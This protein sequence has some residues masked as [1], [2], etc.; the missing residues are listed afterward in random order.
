M[1][2]VNVGGELISVT[3]ANEEDEP[4]LEG[5]HGVFL[6]DEARIL[7]TDE[8]DKTLRWRVLGH[9]IMHACNKYVGLELILHRQFGLTEQQAEDLEELICQIVSPIYLDALER[10]GWLKPPSVK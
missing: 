5:R 2:P 6:G 7:I 3:I 4:D 10:N 9:E 1:K 8:I